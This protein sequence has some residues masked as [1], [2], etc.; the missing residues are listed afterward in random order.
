VNSALKEKEIGFLKI[1]Y[2]GQTEGATPLKDSFQVIFEDYFSL[3]QNVKFYSRL[4]NIKAK[5]I[6]VISN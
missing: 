2:K 3:G 1:G 5:V 4:C 6:P